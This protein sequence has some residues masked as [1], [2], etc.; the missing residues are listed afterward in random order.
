MAPAEGAEDPCLGM[1]RGWENRG[2]EGQQ[3]AGPMGAPQVGK[4]VRRAGD[5]GSAPTLMARPAA[6]AQMHAGVECGGEPCV[7]C[8]HQCQAAGAADAGKI[9]AERGPTRITVVPQD[10]PG[11]TARQ[12]RDS[13]PR[14]GQ[15]ARIGEQPEWGQVRTTAERSVSPREQPPIHRATPGAV[16]TG[17][18]T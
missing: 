13:R 2:E 18:W 17:C 6:T 1:A 15:A 8:Y 5:Q 4:S 10:N 12:P 11:E 7:T 9:A 3:C 14:I 16:L